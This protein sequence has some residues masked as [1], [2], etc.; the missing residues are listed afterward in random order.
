MSSTEFK[1]FFFFNGSQNWVHL[2]IF[3]TPWSQHSQIHRRTSLFLTLSIRFTST[4]LL[5]HGISRIFTLLL[6]AVFTSHVLGFIRH[7]LLLSTLFSLT[8]IY[9]PS[10]IL[11]ATSFHILHPLPLATPKYLKQFTFQTFSQ[12][13]IYFLLKKMLN[14]YVSLSVT[15]NNNYGIWNRIL[16]FRLINNYMPITLFSNLKPTVLKT[17]TLMQSHYILH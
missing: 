1:Q 15:Y 10:C 3:F 14:R 16:T 4:I 11:R 13:S 8:T 9:T 2:L 5:K 12:F 17:T 7:L 6:S